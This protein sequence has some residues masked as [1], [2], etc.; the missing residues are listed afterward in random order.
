MHV[1]KHYNLVLCGREDNLAENNGSLH[2]LVYDYDHVTCRLISQRLGSTQAPTLIYIIAALL[3]LPD[4][5]TAPQLSSQ[6]YEKSLAGFHVTAKDITV[7]P[8]HIN[9]DFMVVDK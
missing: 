7:Q 1:T 4:S 2:S 3:P 6:T 5:V 8:M 9:H